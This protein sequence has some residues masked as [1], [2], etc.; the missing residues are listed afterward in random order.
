MTGKLKRRKI[1]DGAYEILDSAGARVALVEEWGKSGY[2]WR[3]TPTDGSRGWDTTSIAL[4]VDDLTR[5]LAR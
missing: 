3:V 1:E 4:A 5:R 2:R